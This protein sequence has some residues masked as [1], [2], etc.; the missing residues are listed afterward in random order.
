M[1][2]AVPTPCFHPGSAAERARCLV[3]RDPGS[4]AR[5]PRLEAEL[6]SVDVMGDVIGTVVARRP[7]VDKAMR[8][9]ILHKCKGTVTL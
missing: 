9:L 4:L 1:G 7:L 5:S 8:Y 6:S 3:G 2:R